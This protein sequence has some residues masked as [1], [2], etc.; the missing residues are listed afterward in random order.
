[1]TQKKM[2][3][4]ILVGKGIISTITV[5]RMISVA[6]RCN[7]KFGWILEDTGL[8]TGA[9]LAEALA[10]QFSMKYVANIERFSYPKNLLELITPETAL[11][12]HLF[13]LKLEG[14]KLALALADPTDLKVANNIAQNNKVEIVPFIATR[15]DIY[16]AICKHY[17]G[18]T[19]QETT[20]NS[21]LIVDDDKL[22][23]TVMMDILKSHGYTVLVAG[24]GMEGFRE[25]IAYR[26]QVV[27]ADK[28]MPKFDGFAMMKSIQAIPAIRSIPVIL[29]SDKTTD[30][31]EARIFDLGFFDFIT[32]PVKEVTLLSRVKRA[33]RASESSCNSQ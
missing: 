2:L 33:I 13:P 18:R 14:N 30:Q 9:E 16:A 3:G 19:M 26:P 31:D 12:H 27:L 22:F 23:R 24:D 6:R 1:M 8:V 29:V 7:K 20:Q 32:K 17:L 10:D 11:E 28:E 5:D 25:I 15:K 4:E 21:I